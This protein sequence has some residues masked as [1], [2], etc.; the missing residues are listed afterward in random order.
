MS[1]RTGS[2]VSRTNQVAER[3]LRAQKRTRRELSVDEVLALHKRKMNKISETIKAARFLASTMPKSKQPKQSRLFVVPEAVICQIFSFLTVM[4]HCALT[5]TSE[6][7]SKLSL[8]L[9][10]APYRVTLP[11][12]AEIATAGTDGKFQELRDICNCNYNCNIDWVIAN[13]AKRLLRFRAPCLSFRIHQEVQ[14]EQMS[15]MTQL[16]ELTLQSDTDAN[17]TFFCSSKSWEWLANLTNLVK[18]AIPDG[19]IDCVPYF[20]SSLTEITLID[21]DKFDEQSYK[22][23]QPILIE[24][25]FRAVHLRS[26]QVVKSDCGVMILRDPTQEE[27]QILTE[28]FPALRRLEYGNLVYPGVSLRALL[29]FAQLEDLKVACSCFEDYDWSILAGIASLR[30][31][32]IF[33]RKQSRIRPTIFEKIRQV[34]QLT[35]L[36]ID[37]KTSKSKSNEPLAISDEEITDALKCLAMP[38][39]ATVVMPN[40][41]TLILG[42]SFGVKNAKFLDVFSSLTAIQLP[43]T[44]EEFPKLP[45]LCTLNLSDSRGFRALTAYSN[46]LQHVNLLLSNNDNDNH[47]YDEMSIIFRL[48]EMEKLETLGLSTYAREKYRSR[49]DFKRFRHKRSEVLIH[50]YVVD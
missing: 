6:K 2:S 28:S 27:F 46:Q 50:D 8:S 18:L 34:P 43:V 26:L 33:I 9:Q 20:P 45:K 48:R 10:A 44:V 15:A 12:T 47:L 42:T 21:D 19:S 24:T 7:L 38:L 5:L 30:R 49:E 41:Q 4:E 35:H 25:L 1:T 11:T 37:V 22:T 29:P 31:L 17:P 40:L 23:G 16:R 36:E 13:I 3:N 39:V 32:R 14:W